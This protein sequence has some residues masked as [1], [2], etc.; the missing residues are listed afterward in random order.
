MK[1]NVLLKL[2]HGSRTAQAKEESQYSLEMSLLQFNSKLSNLSSQQYSVPYA[3]S[4]VDLAAMQ[5]LIYAATIHLHRDALEVNQQSYQKCVW[6][7][8]RITALIRQIAE[9][10]YDMFCPIISVSVSPR[11]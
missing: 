11:P 8:N 9:G 7:A 6:A 2:E 10:D 3:V 5:M 4:A 1:N